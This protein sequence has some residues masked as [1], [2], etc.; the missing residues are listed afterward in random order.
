MVKDP[1]YFLAGGGVCGA[2]ARETDWSATPL[3]PPPSWPMSLKSV[4]AM[5]LQSRHPMF[6][7]WGESLIQFY[8]DAYLPSFGRGKHPSAMGQRGVDCW[9]EVWPIIHPQIE[10][11]MLRGHASWNEDHLVP[12]ERNDR[13]EEVIY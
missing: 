7:W 6:L 2:L 4:V 12:I 11:V 3:G 9:H 1:L 13:I 10:D 8:N 5:I